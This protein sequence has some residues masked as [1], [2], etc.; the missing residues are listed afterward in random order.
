MIATKLVDVLTYAA[1]R[2]SESPVGP[3]LG[4]GTVLDTSPFRYLLSPHFGVDV[5]SAHTHIIG[6]HGYSEVPVW[7]LANIS[8]MRL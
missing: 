4:S 1:S 5:R 6:E 8:G 3:V 7:S 2:L